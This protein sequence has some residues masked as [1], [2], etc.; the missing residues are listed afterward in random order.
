M[1]PFKVFFGVA[2]AILLF[3]FVVRIAIM[4]FIIAAVMSIIYAVYRRIR[5]YITYDRYGDPYIP[6]YRYAR[7]S[8]PM[9]SQIS[10]EVEPLFHN[11]PSRQTNHRSNIQ[12]IKA[13]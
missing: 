7:M 8:N 13:L 2:I 3:F 6:E 12:Y 5:D 10:N 4:A 9:S 1:R 11:G